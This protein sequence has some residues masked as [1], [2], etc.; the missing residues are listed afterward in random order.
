MTRNGKLNPPR[1]GPRPSTFDQG[2]A[3][4]GA[5]T[6]PLLRAKP[7]R[8]ET[9]RGHAARVEPSPPPI[10]P[11]TMK[12]LHAETMPPPSVPPPRRD[13]AWDECLR[14]LC[15]W[16]DDGQA[17]LKFASK[18]PGKA[19]RQWDVHMRTDGLRGDVHPQANE[20]TWSYLRPDAER[21]L[22]TLAR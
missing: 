14:E 16:S 8:P 9:D 19:L 3:P 21:L 4:G 20:W 22:S 1:Q 17:L 11:P 2:L 10:P 7:G 12:T 5:G 18:S 15:G 6:Q 13:P